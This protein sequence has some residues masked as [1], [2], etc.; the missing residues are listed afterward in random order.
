MVSLVVGETEVAVG[1]EEGVFGKRKPFLCHSRLR[2]LQ[3][4][5]PTVGS[6]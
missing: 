5:L 4:N 1:V 2:R 3:M 6:C